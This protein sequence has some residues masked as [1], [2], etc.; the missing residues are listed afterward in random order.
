MAPAPPGNESPDW[1]VP[2]RSVTSLPRA[3]P[4]PGAPA[5]SAAG[6]RKARSHCRGEGERP[7]KA[8]RKPAKCSFRRRGPRRRG[9]GGTAR[10]CAGRKRK[11]SAPAPLLPPHANTRAPRTVLPSLQPRP[12]EGSS[13]SHLRPC[14]TGLLRFLPP[15]APDF[16]SLRSGYLVSLFW[17]FPLPEGTGSGGTEGT[18]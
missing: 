10:L 17:A 13:C 16:S 12:L 6:G 3:S 5:Q 1:F 7:G 4:R 9:G 14:V 2:P 11:R 18:R 8:V 15:A